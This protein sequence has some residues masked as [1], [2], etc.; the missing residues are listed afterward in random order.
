LRFFGGWLWILKTKPKEGR[1]TVGGSHFSCQ[2]REA[3]C[4]RVSFF[5]SKEGGGRRVFFWWDFSE[6]FGAFSSHF[7]AAVWYFY[8]IPLSKL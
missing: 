6:L 4:R 3:Y 1:H 2:R 5:M 7:L 8:C